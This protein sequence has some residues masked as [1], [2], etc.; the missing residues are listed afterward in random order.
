MTFTS[1]IQYSLLICFIC[2]SGET[3][4]NF[5]VNIIVTSPHIDAV[6]R[7]NEN[8][9]SSVNLQIGDGPL[10]DSVRENPSNFDLCITWDINLLKG[11]IDDDDFYFCKNIMSP[12]DLPTLIPNQLSGSRKDRIF[13]AW[14]RDTRSNPQFDDQLTQV[15]IPYQIEEEECI[16]GVCMSGTMRTFSSITLRQRFIA[17]MHSLVDDD[18]CKVELLLHVSTAFNEDEESSSIWWANTSWTDDGTGGAQITSFE[19]NADQISEAI[20][21][22]NKTLIGES[23]VKLVSVKMFTEAHHYHVPNQCPNDLPPPGSYVPP[24]LITT[25]INHCGFIIILSV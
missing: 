24:L 23:R 8:V 3:R 17:A 2:A 22:L 18:N 21:F 16:V 9:W 5:D 19:A 10:A 13:R 4:T 7:G 25:N 11:L 6:Y 15:D 14:L 12:G 20:N 1:I